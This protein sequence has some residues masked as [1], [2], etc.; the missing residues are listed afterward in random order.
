MRCFIA[1]DVESEKISNIVSELK[2]YSGIKAVEPQ[3]IHITLK[4]L[5]EINE[6]TA[7]KIYNIMQ[8]LFNQ[9]E[10]F[11]IY[12]KKL[13]AF[14][15]ERYPRVLWIGIEKNRD[16]IIDMQKKLDEKLSYLGFK[17]E[18]SYEPHI[19]IARVKTSS[20]RKIVQSFLNKAKD[21]DIGTYTV[22]E[23]KLKKSVLTREGPIYSD[24]YVL[25]L[26]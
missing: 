2:K 4:F 8:E 6:K 5:G 24:L 26:K 15:N 18:K 23:I 17:K 12:I 19:T 13:G 16:K 9:T 25:K 22:E 11:E 3:N 7:E 21:L 1:I 14:P 20:G 10:K